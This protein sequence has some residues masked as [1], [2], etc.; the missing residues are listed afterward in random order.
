[1]YIAGH[2]GIPGKK[3]ADKAAKEGATIPILRGVKRIPRDEQFTA[4]SHLHRKTKEMKTRETKKWLQT[5]LGERQGYILPTTKKPD[6]DA[7]KEWK[8]LVS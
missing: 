7:M 4:I 1:M 3:E 2:E 6:E 8:R 5:T